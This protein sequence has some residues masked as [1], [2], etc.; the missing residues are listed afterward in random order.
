MFVYQDTK[1]VISHA[2]LVEQQSIINRKNELL[3]T[4]ANICTYAELA[5]KQV[6]LPAFVSNEAMSIQVD[7]DDLLARM[8]YVKL[9]PL[10]F[11]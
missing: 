6:V 1:E 7:Q 11:T 3:E 9:E 2:H 8:Q 4:I 10:R 5:S